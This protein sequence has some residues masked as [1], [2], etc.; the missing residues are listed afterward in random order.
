VKWQKSPRSTAGNIMNYYLQIKIAQGPEDA[1]MPFTFL[2]A[3][4]KALPGHLT[5]ALWRAQLP[6]AL[7]R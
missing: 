7:R 6:R 5:A 3:P 4:D 1:D 2:S